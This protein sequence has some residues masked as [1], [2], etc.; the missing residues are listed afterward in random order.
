MNGTPHQTERTRASLKVPDGRLQK[1]ASLIIA[2]VILMVISVMG[3]SGMRSAMVQERM[4]GNM[5]DRL[6]ALED[7]E[8]KLRQ[9]E[10]GIDTAN[11][12][13][14]SETLF[15]SLGTLEKLAELGEIQG[16]MNITTYG[17]TGYRAPVTV[18]RI[19]TEGTTSRGTTEVRLSV[20]YGRQF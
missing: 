13:E 6:T 19:E 18:I 7:A 14:A 3:M 10:Q 8:D 1:G 16:A 12:Y 17:A 4:S 2:M 11:S 5:I 20:D 9:I 15:T